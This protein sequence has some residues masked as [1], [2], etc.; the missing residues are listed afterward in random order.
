VA[1]ETKV[2]LRADALRYCVQYGKS[3]ESD[4]TLRMGNTAMTYTGKVAPEGA[5]APG[6]SRNPEGGK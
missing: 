1:H 5:E 6:P 2:T 4:P 3:A